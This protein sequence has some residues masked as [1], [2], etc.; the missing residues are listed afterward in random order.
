MQFNYFIDVWSFSSPHYWCF[1]YLDLSESH[2]KVKWT[3]DTAWMEKIYWREQMQP[4][5]SYDDTRAHPWLYIYILQT[6]TTNVP[7]FDM[8]N[9]VLNQNSNTREFMVQSFI[10]Q[11]YFLHRF[12]LHR[13]VGDASDCLFNAIDVQLLNKS[14]VVAL[15]EVTYTSPVHEPSLD[16]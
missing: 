13:V 12:L 3:Q 1:L 16:G 7:I 14:F 6:K 5:K 15:M 8:G 9:C 2:R 4:S 11:T 10:F